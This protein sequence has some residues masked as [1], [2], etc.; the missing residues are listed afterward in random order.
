MNLG[1]YPLVTHL[2]AGDGI[3]QSGLAVGLLDRY[4]EIAFPCYPQYEATFR[5]IFINFPR[6]SIY[7]VERIPG[8]DWGSP[9]DSTY[10]AAISVAGMA[11]RPHIRAG[12]YAGRGIGWDFSKSFYEHVNLPYEYRW[13]RCP[14]RDAAKVHAQLDWPFSGRR[15]FVHEDPV[16]GFNIRDAGK[17]SVVFRPAK[18]LIDRS[19]LQYAYMINTADEIHCIDSAFFHLVDSLDPVGRLHLHCYARWPRGR[20]FRYENRFNWNYIF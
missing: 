16:R 5:S 11:G 4:E 19:I 18:E 14:I 1:R 17:C 10:D 6:I 15:A 13:R 12:V 7:T 9:R 20:D 2:G 3:L 8:E